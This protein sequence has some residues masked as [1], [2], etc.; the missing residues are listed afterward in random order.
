MKPKNVFVI[1]LFCG[2]GGMT[3]GLAKEGFNVVA[4]FD[5]DPT[6]KYPYEVNNPGSR[7]IQ[8]DIE[9]ANLESIIDIYPNEPGVRVLVGCAPCQP[10]SRYTQRYTKQNREDAKWR[11]VGSFGRA[12]E[13]VQ[14]DIVSMENVPEL[15][16]HSVFDEFLKILDSN[17][18]T[19]WWDIIHCVDYG[20]PQTRRRLVLLASRFGDIQIIPK[21]H[22]I[23]VTVRQSINSLS[24][25][26][27]GEQHS[28]DPIHFASGLSEINLF[29]IQNTSEGGGWKDWPSELV[30]ACHKKE[31][32]KTYSNIYG[33]MWWDKPAPTITTEFNAIGSGRFGHP[34]QDRAI[35]L[36]EGAL[37]QTFPKK[38]RFAK[39][40]QDVSIGTIA[41]HIGNAVPVRLA[42]I[43][44]RSIKK[45]I[46]DAL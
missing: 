27:A 41:R 24:A 21:T 2:V 33:R 9:T 12:I 29:R 4:G 23:P 8:Q 42:Q 25:I 18:Y 45:H 5:I 20:V 43:I 6:C 10:F 30:L 38:Y 26:D 14:P 46:T 13:G 3:Y 28:K 40:R 17:N 22:L 15:A 34:V 39:R 37:L 1:D 36:R 11:L 7:F 16:R 31:T 32:G 44:G 19:V 35:S